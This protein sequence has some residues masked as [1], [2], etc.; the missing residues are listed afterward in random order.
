M[1]NIDNL[2]AESS[3]PVNLWICYSKYNIQAHVI[4]SKSSNS[5]ADLFGKD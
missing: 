3:L 1:K 4:T 5:I 2:F